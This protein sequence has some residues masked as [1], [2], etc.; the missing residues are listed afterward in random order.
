MKR[1]NDPYGHRLSAQKIWMFQVS[2]TPS[3][4]LV[5]KNDIS[6]EPSLFYVCPSTTFI[7]LDF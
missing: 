6:V 5:R 7:G 4:Y 1:G 2:V 3:K